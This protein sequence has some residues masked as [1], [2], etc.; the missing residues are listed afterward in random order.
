[1]GTKKSA[2]L[3]LST[4]HPHISHNIV[5]LMERMPNISGTT[6]AYKMRQHVDSAVIF[7][8]Y[9]CGWFFCPPTLPPSLYYFF[10]IHLSSPQY[11]WPWEKHINIGGICVSDTCTILYIPMFHLP[12]SGVNFSQWHQILEHVNQRRHCDMSLKKLN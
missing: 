1:M 6:L 12:D 11:L 2:L 9:K 3:L 7:L 5:N 10:R 4:R 8:L